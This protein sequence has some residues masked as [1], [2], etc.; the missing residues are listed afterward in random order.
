MADGEEAKRFSWSCWWP[1]RGAVQCDEL[2]EAPV[3]TA[4]LRG[5]LQVEGCVWG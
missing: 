5:S 4:G 1:G 2:E 3:K